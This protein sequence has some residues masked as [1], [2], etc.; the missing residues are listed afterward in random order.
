MPRL[1]A[2]SPHCWVW[3]TPGGWEGPSAEEYVSAHVP[4]VAWLTEASGT[5]GEGGAQL[6][7][8]V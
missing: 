8:F 4:Y 3:Y 5:H 6:N 1:R 7:V 2:N